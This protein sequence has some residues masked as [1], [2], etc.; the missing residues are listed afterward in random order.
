MEALQ[1]KTVETDTVKVEQFYDE[2][3]A[4]ASYGIISNGE[5]ALVDPA[6]DP[7]PYEDWARENGAKITAIFETHPHADFASGHLELSKRNNAPIYVNPKMGVFYEHTALEDGDE[8]KI[9]DATIRAIETLGHSPDHH[10]YM[11]ID[12]NGKERGIFTGDSL[13]V[14]DI[15]RPDLRE[16]AGNFNLPKEELAG[17]MYDTMTGI[18]KKF[19]DEV[20]V[21]PAHGAGSA[22]GKNMVKGENSSTMAKERTRNWAL[23]EDDRQAFVNNL[24]SDQPAVPKY[25]PYEVELNRQ[26]APNYEESVKAVK[27][28]QSAA[29]IE[30]GSLVIDTRPSED[31]RAGHIEGSINIPDGGKFESWLGSLISPEERFY[32]IGNDEQSL[33]AVIRKS[34]KIGYE[35]HIKGAVTADKLEGQKLETAP[36]E[37][38]R[39]SPTT[40]TIV[41]VRNPGEVAEKKAFDNSVNI[42]LNTLRDRVDEI[43]EDK[44]ITVHCAAG[45]RSAIASSI[46]QAK[47]GEKAQ[48]MD[49]SDSIKH[50]L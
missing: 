22:C 39:S 34:A 12:E 33:D 49:I 45:Y 23:Q 31:F 3:L 37:K 24:L 38:L 7:K 17:K 5:A 2:G 9:G 26:G 1:N 21:Y 25:F 29:D 50:W 10:S 18:F 32:F 48:I 46:L 13:F 27:R 41:D 19:A 30:K 14:G 6:R 42:P 43:P 20:A 11:L 4:Q 47:K 36:V 15:G 8:V 16:G 28:M 40:F 35:G 44:P